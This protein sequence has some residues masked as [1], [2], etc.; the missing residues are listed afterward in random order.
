MPTEVWKFYTDV[1]IHK[2]DL[3]IRGGHIAADKC[4]GMAQGLNVPNE[5]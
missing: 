1:D 2:A 3:Q 4:L 5:R